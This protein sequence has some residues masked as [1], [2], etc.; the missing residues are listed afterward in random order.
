MGWENERRNMVENNELNREKL[1]EKIANDMSIDDLVDM[2]VRSMVAL[3]ERDE[4][5]F[6]EDWESEL[7][8]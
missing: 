3:Y 5:K 4:E 7:G 2:A 8:K 6:Q 1:A